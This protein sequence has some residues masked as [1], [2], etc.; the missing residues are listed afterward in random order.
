MQIVSVEME[1][2]EQNGKERTKRSLFMGTEK[3]A[4]SKAKKLKRKQ[5]MKTV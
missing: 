2:D 1:G 5:K 3:Q 4:I